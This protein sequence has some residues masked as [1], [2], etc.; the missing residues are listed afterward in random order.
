M[1]NETVKFAVMLFLFAGIAGLA[2]GATFQ[3]T[4]VRIADNDAGVL[5][6]ALSAVLPPHDN[7][8]FAD[9][10]AWEVHR[11]R[12]LAANAG[13]FPAAGDAFWRGEVYPARRGGNWNGAALQVQETGYGGPVVTVIGVD[14]RGALVNIRVSYFAQETPGLGTKITE[15]AFLDGLQYKDR[16]AQ[17]FRSLD[18][19]ENFSVNKDG[20]EIAAVTGATISSRAVVNAV[21][22]GVARLAVLRYVLAMPAAPASRTDT[23]RVQPVAEGHDG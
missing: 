9:K 15:P 10:F 23:G 6:E 1:K 13:L 12:L 19:T 5:R 8:P 18:N 3:L 4:Q 7:D 11:V 2:L 17:V 16:A 14:G 21:A 20:G 22:Q